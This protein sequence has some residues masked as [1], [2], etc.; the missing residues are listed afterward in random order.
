MLRLAFALFAVQAGFHGFTA[1][2][3][4]ALARAGVPDPQIGLVVGTAAIVQIPAAFL[5]GI[6]V[7]RVGGV[8]AFTWAGLAYLMG[9][10]S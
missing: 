2:L 9:C 7:D 8:R 5:A 6:V 10:R 3:P 1:A 4:V